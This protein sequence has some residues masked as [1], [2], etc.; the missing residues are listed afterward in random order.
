MKP[1]LLV[2]IASDIYVRNYVESGVLDGLAKD[3]ELHFAVRSSLKLKKRVAEL[4]ASCSEYDCS[5]EHQEQGQLV[6]DVLMLRFASKS[7]SFAFRAKRVFPPFLYTLKRGHPPWK[8]FQQ[9]LYKARLGRLSSDGRFDEFKRTVIDALE[10]NADL[11]RVVDAVDPALVI[12]PSSAYSI[13]SID[14]AKIC[15]ARG[16]PTLLLVDNWDNLSSKSILWELPDHVAVWGEQSKEHAVDIQGFRP[17]QVTLIGTP[18]FDSYFA[19]RTEA[20]PSHFDFPYALFVGTALP[21]D[22]ARA[23]KLLDDEIEAHPEQYRGLKVV[24][25][26]HPWRLG[27]DSIAGSKL[28]HVVLDPQMEEN[29]LRRQLSTAFQPKLDYYPALLSNAAFALGGVSS[30]LIESMV[31]AK[32]YLVIVYDEAGN[33]LSPRDVYSSYVHFRGLE[34]LQGLAL[35]DDSAKLP[36]L[37]RRTF[38]ASKVAQDFGAVDRERQY[39]LFSDE[40]SYSQRVRDLVDRLVSARATAALGSTSGAARTSGA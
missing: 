3:Y 12:V 36:S 22:E 4:A 18:R 31:F 16:V 25:R 21:F 34:R 13:D 8:F 5:P 10:P 9:R 2:L 27:T 33:F 30:M 29:Y 23:L 6:F 19:L 17:D 38:E 15:R 24:Y 28:K 20:L 37:F 14:I 32:R 7:S 1:R 39:F 35:C 26:P 11:A 40:R